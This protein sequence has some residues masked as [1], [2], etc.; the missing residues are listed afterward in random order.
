M[1][2]YRIGFRWRLN[3]NPRFW[4]QFLKFIIKLVGSKEQLENKHKKVERKSNMV[5][6]CES[7][8]LRYLASLCY[9]RRV[10]SG[11]GFCSYDESSEIVASHEKAEIF[12]IYK[13]SNSLKFANLSFCVCWNIAGSERRR[14]GEGS[15]NLLGWTVERGIQEDIFQCRR[16]GGRL[17]ELPANVLERSM[18]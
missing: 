2:T 11:P 6:N 15:F 7:H 18:A 16:P 13:Y 4:W 8:R 12:P 5:F 10:F 3:P 17:P 14:G 9:V 1:T